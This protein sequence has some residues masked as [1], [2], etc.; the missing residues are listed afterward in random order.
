MN[1]HLGPKQF[2]MKMS[3]S[4]QTMEVGTAERDSAD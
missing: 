3:M 4:G 1:M 2:A